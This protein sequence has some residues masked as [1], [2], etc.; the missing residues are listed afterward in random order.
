M[1]SSNCY[2]H[3]I[4]V[5]GVSAGPEIL[6]D[7]LNF[8]V[9]HTLHVVYHII[10]GC[11][12]M[13][14]ADDVPVIA[15]EAPDSWV[16]ALWK[17][18]SVEES[19]KNHV[20]RGFVKLVNRNVSSWQRQNQVRLKINQYSSD[21]GTLPQSRSWIYTEDNCVGRY[22]NRRTCCI[23]IFKSMNDA[24]SIAMKLQ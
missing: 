5:Y 22:E 16:L 23:E 1:I 9:R 10:F 3:S 6:A 17:K 19:T 24:S 14:S 11:K 20:P 12:A 2:K 13:I 8:L 4:K 21:L 15:P 18:K 7:I